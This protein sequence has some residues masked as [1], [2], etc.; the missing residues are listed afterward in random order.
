MPLPP[1][2][3]LGLDPEQIL[4]RR[5]EQPVGLGERNDLRAKV[6]DIGTRR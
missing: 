5:D 3:D 1:L 2:S 4:L 6:I